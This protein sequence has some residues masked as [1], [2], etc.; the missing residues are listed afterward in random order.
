MTSATSNR[1]RCSQA[2]ARSNGWAIA[3]SFARRSRSSPMKCRA[4]ASDAASFSTIRHSHIT[5]CN[6]GR[7]SSGRHR[8]DDLRPALQR[9]MWECLIVEKDAASLARARHFIGDER[10][11]LANDLAIAQPFDLALACEHRNLLDVAEVIV[12]AASLRTESRGSHVR[13]DF[14]GRDDTHWMTNLFATRY[15]GELCFERSWVA[16]GQGWTDRPGDMRIK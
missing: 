14:P 2:S 5:R 11:R 6:A 8:P 15:N 4:R 9:V 12:E 1:L 13:S 7:R 3:R 10:D 16:Q